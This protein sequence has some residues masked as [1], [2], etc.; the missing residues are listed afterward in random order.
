MTIQGEG[1]RKPNG[2]EYAVGR[3]YKKLPSCSELGKRVAS[4]TMDLLGAKKIPTET[5][6][7]IIE[8]R[9]VS[10]LLDYFTSAMSGNAL[11]QKQSFLLDKKGKK[12]GSDIFTLVDDPHIIEALGSCTYDGDGFATKKRTMVEKGVLNE[13]FI[14]WYRS[15]KL[16]VEPTTGGPSNLLLPPGNRSLEE[17]MKDLGRGILINGFIG[18]NSNSNTGDFSVG[19]TGKLFDKGEFVQNVAEMNIADNHLKFWNKLV[20]AAN[21]PWTYSSIRMPSLVF[22]DIVV[23]GI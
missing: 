20:E 16:G 13:Y 4:R 1:D 3:S 5:L 14:D 22:E 18:G 11:Q 6:P 23:S 15:R 9:N 8:N 12:V 21:D 10:N 19:I 2:Y 17:I 7:V